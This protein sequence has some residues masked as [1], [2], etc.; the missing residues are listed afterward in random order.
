MTVSVSLLTLFCLLSQGFTHPRI[1]CAPTKVSVFLSIKYDIWS[2]LPSTTLYFRAMK[3]TTATYRCRISLAGITQGFVS[4][5]EYHSCEQWSVVVNSCVHC[6][7]QWGYVECR[8][9]SSRV[10][11]GVVI[12]NTPDNSISPPTLPC[13]DL[14]W[15]LYCLKG[16]ISQT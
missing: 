4:A 9:L 13:L 15:T 11:M 8:V 5:S 3:W 10:S 2:L 6:N 7:V 12:P 1:F 16:C 14:K